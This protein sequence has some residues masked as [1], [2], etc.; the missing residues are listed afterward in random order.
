[1]KNESV[2][3]QALERKPKVSP[4]SFALPM[5]TRLEMIKQAAEY[6][7]LKYMQSCWIKFDSDGFTGW[8]WEKYKTQLDI[9]CAANRYKDFVIAGTR[10]NCPTMTMTIYLVGIDALMEYAGPS[11]KEQGFIDQFGTFYNRTDAMALCVKNGRV[12]KELGYQSDKLF[13][14]HLC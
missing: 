12:L 10:H 6:A 14:E 1:M 9:V 11:G 13:S 7:Q 3:T 5:A 4:A 8:R 2:F